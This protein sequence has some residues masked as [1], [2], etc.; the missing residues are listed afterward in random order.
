[1][2]DAILSPQSATHTEH[3]ASRFATV[4]QSVSADL[5]GNEL[6]LS[7]FLFSLIIGK[8]K[9]EAKKA[10]QD[11]DISLFYLS[12]FSL[13][14]QGDFQE[15]IRYLSNIA[16]EHRDLHQVLKSVN[17]RIK[18]HKSTGTSSNATRRQKRSLPVVPGKMV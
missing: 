5:D 1:M 9:S 15:V 18:G 10:S 11:A 4:S 2:T 17:S 3:F 6:R 13:F 7:H 12:Y 8:H 16:V 14:A